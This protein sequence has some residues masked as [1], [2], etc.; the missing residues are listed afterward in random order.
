MPLVLAGMNL[1]VQV[2]TLRLIRASIRGWPALASQRLSS[3]VMVLAHN[4]A[5]LNADTVGGAVLVR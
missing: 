4:K 1:R 3:F 2:G 5:K